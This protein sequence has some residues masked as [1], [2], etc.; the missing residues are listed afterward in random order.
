M[1]S[2]PRIVQKQTRPERGNHL[3]TR[4]DGLHASFGLRCRLVT[5]KGKESAE[6]APSRCWISD[7]L[8]KA[9]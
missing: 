3:T 8:E 5:V 7:E 4:P 1:I 9:Y 6:I 2:P